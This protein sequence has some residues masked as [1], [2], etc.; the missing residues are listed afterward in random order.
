ML[1]IALCNCRFLFLAREKKE[2]GFDSCSENL[3]SPDY[4]ALSSSILT[5][6]GEKQCQ[7][8]AKWRL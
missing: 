6:Q 1:E 3:E 2:H 5:P 4:L 8:L 7:R